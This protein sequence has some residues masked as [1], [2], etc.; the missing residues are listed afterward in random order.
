[1]LAFI[2][3]LVPAVSVSA[4]GGQPAAGESQSLNESEK[5]ALSEVL[6]GIEAQKAMLG[7]SIPGVENVDFNYL[8]LGKPIR[9]YIYANDT[10]E[11]GQAMYPIT[12]NDELVFWAIENEGKFQISTGL[13]R[14]VNNCLGKDIAFTL[15]YDRNNAYLYA[16]DTFIWLAGWTDAVDSRSVL[17]PETVILDNVPETVS[18]SEKLEWKYSAAVARE[19]VYYGCNVAYVP[20]YPYDELC[21]SA[22]LVCITNYCKGMSLE[23]EEPAQYYCQSEDD[24]DHGVGDVNVPGVFAHYDMDYTYRNETP[25]DSVIGKNIRA[26][27][28]VY[29]GWVTNGGNHH[30]TCIYGINV[31]GGSIYI[32]DPEFGFTS[33][34]VSR[35]GYS[36]VSSYSDEKLTLI[37][38][39][40]HSW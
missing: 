7:K 6:N 4:V 3:C 15:I 35:N 18:L 32:M 31:V 16:D 36:Y 14:E 37:N 25:S 28:P 27:Y 2:L 21:W 39:V 34:S 5:D 8:C 29:A 22:V 20:Q 9:S 10:F 1:M 24:Y 12:Y 33:A 13:T 11:L 19:P 17:E 23:I 40:C 38:L 30:A 26:D